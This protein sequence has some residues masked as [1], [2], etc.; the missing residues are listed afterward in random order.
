MHAN[1]Y[2]I[3]L[4]SI[5]DLLAKCQMMQMKA[6]MNLSKNMNQ[7]MNG[8]MKEFPNLHQN[9]KTRKTFFAKSKS[10]GRQ[11][12]SGNGGRKHLNNLYIVCLV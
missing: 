7:D 2:F 12:Q 3:F 8:I 6:T 11:R 1:Q 9:E 10:I 5:I 4:L